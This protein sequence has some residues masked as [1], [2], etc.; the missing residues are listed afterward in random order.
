MGWRHIPGATFIPPPH[1]Q[2]SVSRVLVLFTHCL[3]LPTH[4]DTSFSQARCDEKGFLAICAFGLPARSHE[5]DPARG[6]IA[7]LS[8]AD[9]VRVRAATQGPAVGVCCTASAVLLLSTALKHRHLRFALHVCSAAA[10][11]PALASPL[12]ACSA[13]W[14]VPSGAPSIQC[15]EMPSTWQLA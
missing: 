3:D 6:V 8:I 5:D 11:V 15:L 2:N 7:A 13:P 4:F 12:A 14:S 9:A 10:G 1:P